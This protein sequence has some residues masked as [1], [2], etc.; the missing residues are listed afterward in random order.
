[1]RSSTAP[2]RQSTRDGPLALLVRWLPPRVVRVG[3]LVRPL[4]LVGAAPRPAGRPLLLLRLVGLLG[5]LL[6]PAPVLL[7]GHGTPP[8]ST[9]G[10]AP[11]RP[12]RKRKWCKSRT[13]RPASPPLRCSRSRRPGRRPSGG[14]RAASASA[15]RFDVPLVE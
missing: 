13:I 5:P 6:L 8:C 7:V 1:P 9:A 3:R 12:V 14:K 10:R 15:C 11:R 4:V 2:T